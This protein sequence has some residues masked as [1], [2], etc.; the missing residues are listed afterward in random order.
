MRVRI[1]LISV[2]FVISDFLAIALQ[3]TAGIETGKIRS[4]YS[5]SDTDVNTDSRVGLEE[6][7]YIL[8]HIA[9]LRDQQ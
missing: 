7:V 4:D 9:G 8:E 3:E 1:I 5:T 6:A 2:S